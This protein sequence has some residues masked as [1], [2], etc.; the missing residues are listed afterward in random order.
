MQFFA[1]STLQKTQ[2]VSYDRFRVT[3]AP[4]GQ[5]WGHPGPESTEVVHR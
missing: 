5:N 3:V 1:P 2:V 4:R